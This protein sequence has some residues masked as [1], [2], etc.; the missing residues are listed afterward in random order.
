MA[1]LSDQEQRRLARLIGKHGLEHIGRKLAKL[2]QPTILV[3]TSKPDAYRRRGNS[4]FGG[5]PDLP[6]NLEWPTSKRGGQL[7][8]LA[9][10]NLKDLPPGNNHPLPARGILYFFLGDDEP[11]WHIENQVL[12]FA[13]GPA[14]LKRSAEPDEDGLVKGWD[15]EPFQPHRIKARRSVSLPQYRSELYESLNLDDESAQDLSAAYSN[16]EDDLRTA[17]SYAS[18]AS[19]LLGYVAEFSA[20]PAEDAHYFISKRLPFGKFPSEKGRDKAGS[21][22]C[23]SSSL[24]TPTWA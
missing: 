14:Q 11:A 5:V 9:Q 20:H 15:G 13:G 12:Y 3:T 6:P 23:S 21:G 10:I 17:D 2:A 18:P 19:R 8:F 22:S 16:L 24:R 4:R 7:I 1:A